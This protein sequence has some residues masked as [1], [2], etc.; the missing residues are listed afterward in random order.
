M[1]I[2]IEFLRSQGIIW[3][4]L[5][6]K[7]ACDIM[8]LQISRDSGVENFNYKHLLKMG[9]IFAFIHIGILILC[10]L[11]LVPIFGLN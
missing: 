2:L 9:V 11:I 5:S 1:K 6:F 4:S 7:T 8:T 10:L 3:L